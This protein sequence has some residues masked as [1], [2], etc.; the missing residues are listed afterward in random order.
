M[1]T[2]TKKRLS[3]KFRRQ[4]RKT[5]ATLFMATAIAVAAIPVSPVQADTA[6]GG[7]ISTT[8]GEYT[9]TTY[10]YPEDDKVNQAIIEMNHS[11]T[12]VT[13]SKPADA[14]TTRTNVILED[15]DNGILLLLDRYEC[16]SVT[17]QPNGQPSN[18]ISQYYGN[19]AVSSLLIT[20]NEPSDYVI[21]KEADITAFLKS[22]LARKGASKMDYDTAKASYRTEMITVEDYK[23]NRVSLIN[24]MKRFAATEFS[25]WESDVKQ[26]LTTAPFVF[27]FADIDPKLFPDNM[28]KFY[29][30]FCYYYEANLQP[31]GS[32]NSGSIVTSSGSGISG[33]DFSGSNLTGCTLAPVKDRRNSQNEEDIYV[34][35]ISNNKD[36]S[37]N[38]S[39]LSFD[40]MGFA[41]RKSVP[42][43]GIGENAFK[44]VSNVKNIEL[45]KD[46]RYI[47][48]S[49]FENCNVENFT[50]DNEILYIGNRAFMN[51]KNLKTVTLPPNLQTIGVEAF[52]GSNLQNLVLPN[53][54]T[55]IGM[56]AFADSSHLQTIDFTKMNDSRNP[57]CEIGEAAF[58]DNSAL[59]QVKFFPDDTTQPSANVTKI[60]DG[61]FAVSQTPSGNLEKFDLPQYIDDGTDLGACMF[62]NRSN[63]KVINMPSEFGKISRARVPDDFL[64]GVRNLEKLHFPSGDVDFE[65]YAPNALLRDIEN[66]KFMISGPAIQNNNRTTIHKTTL[67]AKLRAAGDKPVTYMYIDSNGKKVYEISNCGGGAYIMSVT[68]DGTLVSCEERIPNNQAEPFEIPAMIGT[69]SVKRIGSGCFDKMKDKIGTLTIQDDSIEELEPSVFEGCSKLTTV[70]LGNS[71]TKIGEKAFNNCPIL[72]NVYFRTPKNGY[73]SLT[74]GEGAFTTNSEKLTFHGDI[75]VNYAPYQYA[76]KPDVWVSS[77][78]TK[79][80]TSVCYKTDYLKNENPTFLTVLKERY[81]E[82]DGS[83][84]TRATLVDYL[85][86]EE[87]PGLDPDLLKQDFNISG[88]N[89]P[90][91]VAKY[92]N[93]EGISPKEEQ[94]IRSTQEIEIPEGID[95]FDV[96]E[97]LESGLNGGNIIAYLHTT[98]GYSQTVGDPMYYGDYA[99]AGYVRFKKEPAKN[100]ALRVDKSMVSV[101][102]EKTYYTEGETVKVTLKDSATYSSDLY[103][104][105]ATGGFSSSPISKNMTSWSFFGWQ[106]KSDISFSLGGDFNNPS[107][108]FTM[109][110]GNLDLNPVFAPSVQHIITAASQDKTLD[111]SKAL[112]DK[113]TNYKYTF[114]NWMMSVSPS[115]SAA[116]YETEFEK[117][118]RSKSFDASTFSIQSGDTITFTAVYTI[119]PFSSSSAKANSEGMINLYAAARKVENT[120]YPNYYDNYKDHGLF[121]GYF[122][123]E[124]SKD[125]YAYAAREYNST[126]AEAL[127]EE[128]DI[129]NDVIT[130]VTMHSV[131]ELPDHAFL[132]CEQLTSID[133]GNSLQKMGKAPFKGCTNL[134]SLKSDG[135]Y[136][137]QN[138]I[139]YTL[140]DDGSYN[141][142]ECLPNRGKGIGS[143][144]Y[145]DESD[146][147]IS[148]IAKLEN[149]AFEGCENIRS[150]DLTKATQLTTVPLDCFR[151]CTE[152]VKVLLPGSI[153]CI[154]SNAFKNTN[155]AYITIPN[156]IL[157]I[158]DHAFDG[159]ET[160]RSYRDGSAYFYTQKYREVYFEAIDLNYTVD[161]IDWDGTKLCDTQY[162]EEGR[163]AVAPPDPIREGYRF[164]GW[165]DSYLGVTKDLLI[166]AKY[167]YND[168][169]TD[170]ENQYQLI[171]ENGYGDGTYAAGTKI[172]ITADA[173]IDG[174][175]FDK[176]VFEGND[177]IIDK[178]N[179]K[180]TTLTMPE[181]N[182]TI[183]ATYKKKTT[184]DNGNTGGG[185]NSG[186]NG[187]NSGNGTGGGGGQNGNSDNNQNSNNNNSNNNNSNNSNNNNSNNN[188]SNNNN[189]NNNN[190][191][192]NSNSNS[193][194]NQTGQSSS[195]NNTGGGGN[196]NGGSGSNNGNGDKLDISKPGISNGDVG[197]VI[198]NGT[199]DNFIVK[200]TESTAATEAVRQALIHEYGSLENV[201]YMAMDISLYDSTGT[202]KITDT[203]GISV[204]ITLPIPDALRQYAGNNKAAG[205]VDSVNGYVLDKMN[206]K[207]STIQGVP[208]ITF[209]ATH[210]SPYT[211]YV[212]TQNLSSGTILDENPKTGDGIHPKWFLSVGLAAA[213]IFLFLKKDKK[214]ARRVVRA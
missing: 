207:F 20:Q 84:A 170:P 46:L 178:V 88:T 187:D 167:E 81:Q 57:G 190:S 40:D 68:D 206:V 21:I 201:A 119:N 101:D 69:Y 98:A 148:K 188:N 15:R 48:N 24:F 179:S 53:L 16:Y 26:N 174:L 184:N 72:T 164:I 27:Y 1:A 14:P 96:K 41:Y 91:V 33:G 175:Q 144:N 176:W 199:N 49:A 18:I 158:Q 202:T 38:L 123:F 134:T 51:C 177:V 196:S 149:G 52:R 111:A 87:L 54:I 75:D 211:I 193:N 116:N 140:N 205:V 181:R 93:G 112:L 153:T 65:V 138:G 197:S 32:G 126:T 204:T 214:P 55:K 8:P 60:G 124:D 172:I 4:V 125:E 208:C 122:G 212:D 147:D 166:I 85:H 78:S 150:V 143:K 99:Y 157:E 82:T 142:V 42:I 209:T 145:P 90:E 12:G 160:I 37:V 114:S 25:Q 120:I 141:L 44:D 131:K 83:I 139:I 56:G 39:H 133:L 195:G 74:I 102:P 135:K 171:V 76:M 17:E 105:N 203:K 100:Y 129:G 64:A 154:E 89:W 156:L 11:Y 5:V 106:V 43:I 161:F 58:Y 23:N 36:N 70:Y 95:S 86:Y 165:S 9:E 67:N 62:Y 213:S 118:Q 28:E 189:S 2:K 117:V 115:T 152:L 146:I 3:R 13:L 113:E 173:P 10:T 182:L 45:G 92:E 194:N 163:N 121:S 155:H 137:V 132:S 97:F 183:K 128:E 30:Y 59:T 180:L 198:V 186:G 71:I 73:D 29:E 66:E 50:F 19:N 35:K 107:V 34:A 103:E 159:G 63:L 104:E 77:L 191:N 6:S 79:I 136:I 80:M 151:D 61:C 130:K 200:I 192:N 7:A 22:D 210:F 185:G 168:P 169:A 127:K 94:I 31:S 47:G 109:P 162:I 110:S 108:T